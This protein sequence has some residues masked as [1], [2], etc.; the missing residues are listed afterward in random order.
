MKKKKERE[1]P[2]RRKKQNP[3]E[4]TSWMMIAANSLEYC[5]RT[6]TVYK[7]STKQT[8]PPITNTK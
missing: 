6:T 5:I 1:I 4:K 7:H 2:S 8:L 3:N